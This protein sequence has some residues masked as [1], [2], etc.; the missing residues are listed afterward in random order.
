MPRPTSTWCRAMFLLF[1]LCASLATAADNTPPE[2]YTA[3]FN[4]KDLTNWKGLVSPDKGPPGRAAL[5]PD[6]LAKAQAE[7]DQQMRDHWSVTDGVLVYDGKGQSICTAQDFGDFELYVDWKIGPEGDSGIYLRGCPQVQI[8]DPQLN[9]D[10][11]GNP[12][13]SGG[14]FNNQKNPSRPSGVADRPIGEWNTFQ[15][16]MMGEKVSVRLNGELVV[17]NV[18]MENYWEREKPIEPTGQIE[19]Q[20]HGNPIYFK[21]VYIKEL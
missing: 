3:L 12:I 16:K 21:N 6:E 7:A 19:L 8:W 18:V 15:I 11:A 10:D 17:D 4:G 20:H 14:L 13:G 1:W 9:K 5:S 2:G